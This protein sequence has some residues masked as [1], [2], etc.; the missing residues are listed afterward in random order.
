MTTLESIQQKLTAAFTPDHLEVINESRN[1]NV[2]KGSESHFK[3]VLVSN[4]FEGQGLVD[5]HRAIYATLDTE[6]KS[7]VHALALHLYTPAEWEKKQSPTKSPPCLGGSKKL[8]WAA[9]LLIPWLTGCDKS[10]T[11]PDRS[12]KLALT[13][14]A[15]VLSGAANSG[16]ESNAGLKRSLLGMVTDCSQSAF[17][18]ACVGGVRTARYASCPI[19]DTTST[20]TGSVTLTYSQSTCSSFSI[21]DKVTRTL[22][23][24]RSNSDGTT[25]TTTSES[26]ATYQGDLLGGG[27]AI[28]TNASDYSLGFLGVTKQKIDHTGGNIYI[29]NLKTASPFTMSSPQLSTVT[30]SGGSLTVTH[31]LAYYTA[32]VSVK[33]PLTYTYATC[34]YPTAGV[35]EA[36]FTDGETGTDTLAFDTTCGKATYTRD[37]VSEEVDLIGCE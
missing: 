12:P 26:R 17:K 20:L 29:M 28:S 34:C 31:N 37:G 9:L 11:E 32:T 23:V 16:K 25:T 2:P 13:V 3:V 15:G 14:A 35:L 18:D 27:T 5:R 4:R 24:D 30:V 7:G 1:H 36:N 33:T 8:A 21:G 10:N 19:G 6:L 22:T